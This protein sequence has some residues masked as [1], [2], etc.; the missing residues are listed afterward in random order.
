MS[1][2]HVDS[3]PRT[4]SFVPPLVQEKTRLLKC[5]WHKKQTRKQKLKN[6][7]E[8]EKAKQMP[9]VAS[10]S[11][12]LR[13]TPQVAS[14]SSSPQVAEAPWGGPGR[15]DWVRRRPM[16]GLLSRDISEDG[17]PPAGYAVLAETLLGWTRNTGPLLAAPT[18][19]STQPTPQM[20][21]PRPQ[22]QPL[23]QTPS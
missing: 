15:P 3:V 16:L 10:S 18:P 6:T 5:V 17:P 9:R 11:C 8:P 7:P 12:G 13:Q 14:F 2:V 22:S 1:T 23:K 21:L 4:S 20:Y 19:L